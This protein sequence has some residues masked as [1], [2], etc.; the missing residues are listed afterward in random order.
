MGITKGVLKRPVT[1]VLVVLCL[2]V[3]GLSS[4]LSS[5]MELTPEMN[6]PMLLINSVYAG[7]NPEDV[8]DL[9]TK[10][11]E[12]AVGTLSGI[13]NVQSSSQENVS[14]VMLEYE[15]GTDMDKAYSDLKKKMDNIDLPDDVETPSIMEFNMNDMPAVTLSVNDPSQENLYNYVNDK[16]V[17]EF[18]KIS[19]VA[20]VDV[21]GG[22]E[23]YIS[24]RLIPEKMNQY[25]LTMN[26]ISQAIKA[27]DFTYPAGN[28]GVGK[29]DLS[30]STGV[31]VKT[32][33]SLKKVPVVAGDGKTIYMEDIAD[34]SE[35]SKEQE[36]IG[37]YNGED[38]IT[39]SINKQQKDSA[40]DVSKSVTRTINTLKQE[41]PNLDIVVIDDTSDQI[42]SALS[43]VKD[44]MIMAVVISMIIIFLFFGDIK[45]SLIVGSSIPVSILVSLILMSAMGFSMNVITMS[46]IVLGVGMMVDNSIVVLESCFRSQKGTGFR[47]YMNA[48]LEGT[49]VVLQSILGG[50]ITTCVVF[51]PLALLEGMTGQL[52]KP[53]GYTIVFCMLAS[54][55]SAMTIVPL[56]YSRF[57]P[58]EKQNSPM[59]GIV[60]AMQNGYRK[61]VDKLLRRRAMVMIVSVLLLVASFFLATKLGF[62]LMP[63]VDQGTITVSAEMKPG[64]KVEE[65]DKILQK[66]EGIVTS[67]GDLKSYMVS[68]GG[69]GLSFSGGTKGTLTAY[70]KDDRKLTTNQIVNKWKKE[71]NQLPDCNITVESS[72]SMSM[73]SSSNDFEVILQSAQLDELKS[74]SDQ[75]VAELTERPELIKVHSDLENA[76]PIIKVRVD[77]IKAAA[78]GVVPSNVGGLLNSMLSG[79]KATTMEVAGEDV[80]VQVEYPED[81][82]DTLDK[83]EGIMIPNSSGGSVALTDIADIGY[84]D[85]P[86]AISRKN[87]QYLV[88]ITG[89]FTDEVK[90]NKDKAAAIKEI[91]QKVVNK[92]LD[93]TVTRAKNSEDESMQEEFGNLLRAIAIAVFLIFVVMAAQFESP[94]F[95]MMVMTTIPFSLIG[96]F[97]FLAAAGVAISMPSLLGFLMLIG[98][99]VN[100]GILYVDTV[101]QYRSSMDKR[102]ALIE[103][104]ATRLRP[105]LMT[106]L[107]TVVS[108]I[109]MAMAVGDSGE[110][111][112]GLA[113][114]NVGGLTASTILSLLMLPVYYSLMSGKVDKSE[115]PD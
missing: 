89:S 5:K 74:I 109:P 27:A 108:M 104:G 86:S 43:S 82:Y 97:G 54:L 111:M 10:P 55:L 42:T 95:S 14:I 33:E 11:V 110:T 56:C 57:R 52:F 4:V 16:I 77:P 38:T 19:S 41:H 28:T 69:S 3:F 59:G 87:K 40:V 22:R 31:E 85:S 71:M 63:A 101:N 93:T 25:H 115:M 100:S 34:I 21:S 12:E 112:Q 32:V 102:T 113:L 30:V 29:R 2:I 23:G 17:P 64:L 76:A 13:K 114:V 60:R 49:G 47:E 84:E 24:V 96:S 46:S 45:A 44:T 6:F 79:T 107:T 36:A 50:T 98:T 94:K 83:V 90:T 48:A 75:M 81:T 7:A 105:I 39:L 20:S 67:E 58:I 18:E 73:M 92:Y 53:L 80:D 70:L 68:Y 62:E 65:A 8:N 35:T 15:Y 9:V 88:T 66:L 51:I 37:R 61:L 91:D 78:E 106:T 99:V 72:S 26:S 103:A 1:T